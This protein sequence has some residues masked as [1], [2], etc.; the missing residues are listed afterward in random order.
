MELH[1]HREMER[2]KER[3]LALS[4][5]VERSLELA[6]HAVV[7]A[8]LEKARRVIQDDKIIDQHEVDL[9]EECLKILALYRPVATDLRMV[10]AI[11]KINNDLERIG[12]LCRNIGEYV[13][14]IAQDEP[15][16]MPE[17][18][19]TMFHETQSMVHNAIDSLISSDA[20]QA[21]AVG[22]KDNVVDQLNVNIIQH[23]RS[24]IEEQPRKVRPLLFVVSISRGVERIADYATNIA[25][26]VVYMV[27]GTI[28]RHHLDKENHG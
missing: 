12:D 20:A 24:L 7:D 6:Q 22:E 27:R 13:L 15:I 10:I 5:E 19:R 8:D 9:E 18:F 1:F 28:V 16:T 14:E 26:D 2:L 17:D 3:L 21:D 4:A 23:I 11:M 25:E